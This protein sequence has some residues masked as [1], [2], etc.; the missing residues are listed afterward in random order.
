MREKTTNECYCSMLRNA[1]SLIKKIY[2]RYFQTLGI[3]NEQFTVLEHIK[4]LEPISITNLSK[5]MKLDRTTLSRNLKVLQNNKLIEDSISFGRSR[6]I[7]LSNEGKIIIEKAEK[8]W[9][10]IQKEIEV[11]LGVER[12]ENIKETSKILEDYFE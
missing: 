4:F 9:E 2:N 6:Q 1:T 5:K 8:I 3:T 10:K 7:V 11:I 12:L